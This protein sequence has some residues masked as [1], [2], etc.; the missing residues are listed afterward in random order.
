MVRTQPSF[1]RVVGKTPN[2]GTCIQRF[3]SILTKGPKAHGR[4][5][6]HTHVIGLRTFFT[7]ESHTRVV[8]HLM[9]IFGGDRVRDPLI[10]FGIYIQLCPKGNGVNLSFGALI[11]DRAFVPV[12]RCTIR[13]ALHKILLNLRAQIFKHITQATEEWKISFDGLPD[14]NHVDNTHVDKGQYQDV[15]KGRINPEV[16]PYSDSSNNDYRNGNE[17]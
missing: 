7:T 2:L 14:L 4:H 3:D 1:A 17:D 11:N 12:N 5:V 9:K 10:P 8:V 13:V 6:K 15:E 16:S